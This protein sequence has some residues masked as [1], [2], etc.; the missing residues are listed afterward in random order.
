MRVTTTVVGFRSLF[1]GFTRSVLPNMLLFLVI[2]F[3]I[4]NVYNYAYYI[5]DYISDECWYVSSARNLLVKVF[6]VQPTYIG[7]D[8]FLGVNVE[9][10]DN[11]VIHDVINTVL[12]SGGRVVKSDYSNIQLVYVEVPNIDVLSDLRSIPGV[13]DVVPG[14]RYPDSREI[15]NY[16]NTE[17]PPLAKYLIALSILTCS[18]KPICW[19]IPSIIASTSILILIYL[20]IRFLVGGATGSYL[21]VVAALIT[22]SDTLFRSLSVVAMLDIFTSLFTVLTLYLLLKDK[23]YSSLTTLGLAFISKYSGWFITPA[24]AY[25]M[26]K[27]RIAPVN[28]M[29]LVTAIPLIMLV[30]SSLPL[31]KSLGIQRWWFE[32]V[33]NAVRWH[34]SIKTISGPP[35]SAP[36]EWLLGWNP[37]VFH[38]TYVSGEWVADLI[39]RGNNILYLTTVATTILILPVISKLPDRGLVT[40]YTWCTF[41]MY[42]VIWLLG[43]KT[44]Y[45]FYM[46]QITPLMYTSLIIHVFW[47]TSTDNFRVLIRKWLT[48]IKYLIKWFRGEVAIK[49]Y[50]KF[51]NV[52]L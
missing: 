2:L 51:E 48:I 29:L 44:Q 34:L 33:E 42:V 14:F 18:D 49:V 35:A 28:T 26:I 38:Y 39:A 25:V 32:A 13:K 7:S 5:D 52:E 12:N 16:L 10:S 45:S 9:V 43:S 21:G 6:N 22:A 27:R 23:I 47:L 37:F 46:V 8:G 20:I 15:T 40:I 19:R 36:W 41:L 1:K 30:I 11:R 3:H 31:I 4:Y 17:H 24:I 50:V